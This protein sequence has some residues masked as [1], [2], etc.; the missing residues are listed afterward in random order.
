VSA[1]FDRQGITEDDLIDFT[2][3]LRQEALEIIGRLDHGPLFSPPTLRGVINMPGGLGGPDWVGAAAHPEKGWMYV[4]SHTLP[5][6]IRL[7]PMDDPHAAQAPYWAPGEDRL[8]GPRGLPLTKPPYG[9]ITAID[10]NTG[11]HVWMV[12]TGSGPVNHPA[13]KDL[14]L[15]ALGYPTR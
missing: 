15:P 5:M 3:E 13:I 10:L 7:V 11:E 2:P 9:R 6:V 1:P 14:D 4:P 12:S 8:D